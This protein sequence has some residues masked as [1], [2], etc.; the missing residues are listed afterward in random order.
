VAGSFTVQRLDLDGDE[1]QLRAV[2]E[3]ES[4]EE[5]GSMLAGLRER[6]PG[7]RISYVNLET[8]L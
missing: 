6:L 2:V 4:E 5:L 7:F 3:P 8:L 1:V